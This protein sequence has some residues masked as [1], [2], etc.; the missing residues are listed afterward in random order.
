MYGPVVL[1]LWML[2]RAGVAKRPRKS[3]AT[4]RRLEGR[5]LFPIVDERGIHR[6]VEVE[7]VALAAHIEAGCYSRARQGAW[8]RRKEAVKAKRRSGGD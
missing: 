4:V 5:V 8:L 7:V 2:T 3:I 6:F 1:E